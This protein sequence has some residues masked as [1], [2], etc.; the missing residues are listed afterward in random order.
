V[1]NRIPETQ[2]KIWDGVNFSRKN[3]LTFQGILDIMSNMQNE[4][5][6]RTVQL[7]ILTG[8]SIFAG[9]ALMLF[10]RELTVYIFDIL[11]LVILF[12]A[13]FEVMR[14]T[15]AKDRGIKYHYVYVYLA[16]AYIMFFVGTILDPAFGFWAHIIAQLAVLLVFVVYT[17]FMYYVDTAFIKK[18]RLKKAK[19][20][21][22][23]WRV[24][25]QYL[26]IIGYPASLIYG[27]FA[28]NHFTGVLPAEFASINMGLFGL[29]LVFVIAASSDTCA[30]AVG[31]IIKG[32][33]LCPKISPGKTWSG[34]IAGLFGGVLGSLILL[35]IFSTDPAFGDFFLSIG[36][37]ADLG[38]VVF[39]L[40]GL[41]GS[42]VTQ[43]AGLFAS[44]LKR[45][46]KIND[47]GKILPGHG[48][49]MDRVDGQIAC[50]VFIFLVLSIICF[51]L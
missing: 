31:N 35:L 24:V 19:V 49:V 2:Q 36:I 42:V 29:L 15:K 46:Y 40:I 39:G 22:E 43:A 12:F 7:R 1:H 28:L 50:A 4:A 33:K 14:A 16:C 26:K 47:Y 48:G 5:V 20:G 34:T 17:F 3:L 8:M 13:V 51:I 18:C 11:L 21:T 32:P 23:S 45:K 25:L 9:L 44:K 27:F 37:N 6:K 30:Y 10:L 41:F 38:L